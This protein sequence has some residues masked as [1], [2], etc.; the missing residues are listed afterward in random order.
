MDTLGRRNCGIRLCQEHR[1]TWPCCPAVYGNC[2]SCVLQPEHLPR[3][4]PPHSLNSCIPS[5]TSSP[6][7]APH[8]AASAAAS[9]CLQQ[10]MIHGG[11]CGMS[12]ADKLYGNLSS[13]LALSLEVQHSWFRWILACWAVLQ[14]GAQRVCWLGLLLG[15]SAGFKSLY[16]AQPHRVWF[17]MVSMEGGFIAPL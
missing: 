11:S 7:T 9:L 12:L 8:P 4:A 16:F 10:P 14:R 2:V 3:A 13:L 1:E 5:P 15:T 17:V 6:K